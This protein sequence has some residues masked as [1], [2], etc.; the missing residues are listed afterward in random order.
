MIKTKCPICGQFD[1][2]EVL[3]EANF[4]KSDLNQNTFSARRLPDK[5]HARI[6]KCKSDGLVRAD[7]FLSVSELN[8]FY[9]MSK[10]TY[11]DEVVNLKK[12]YLSALMPILGKLKKDSKILEVGCGNGFLMEELQKLGFFKVWGFEP[13][14][15]AIE[16]AK[17]KTR[18]RILNSVFGKNQFGKKQ[19]DIICAFQTFDHIANPEV[20]LKDCLAILKPGGFFLTFNHNVESL[21]AKILG[22]R[23]PI[24]DIEHPYLYSKSTIYMLLLKFGFSVEKVYSPFSQISLRQLLIYLPLPSYFKKI[25]LKVPGGFLSFSVYLKLGNLC[26]VAQKAL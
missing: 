23:S 4:S 8:K 6:V 18:A 24:V 19:F 15:E 14:R 22:E 7:P 26:A 3:F 13:S 2:F 10:F 12:T 21:S 11:D 17:P 20:F 1:N 9:G 16:R 25:L 5:I